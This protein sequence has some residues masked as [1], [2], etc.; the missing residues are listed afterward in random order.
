MLLPQAIIKAA[1]PMTERPIRFEIERPVA[2]RLTDTRGSPRLQGRTVNIS[3]GG[4]LFKTEQAVAVG[5]RV[6]MVVRMAQASE[7]GLDVDLH[8]LGRVVRS[9]MGWAAVQ[10]HK[11]QIHPTAPP[12]K[13]PD[14]DR[15]PGTPAG[16]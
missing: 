16:P 1:S 2:F 5:R 9:G 8:L 3:S 4:V 11:Y 6:E 15:K 10:V 14:A 12:G 13:L 7:S